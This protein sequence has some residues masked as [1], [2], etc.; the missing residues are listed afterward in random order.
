MKLEEKITI[1]RKKQ[2]WSQEELAFRLDV[3]R[4]AVSKWE[5][6]ASIPDLDKIIKMSEIFGV[7][8][9]YL[10]KDDATNEHSTTGNKIM[11]IPPKMTKAPRHV[12][13]EE[14][15]TYIETIK[16][17][18]REIAIG[19]ALCIL[20]PICLLLLNGLAAVDKLSNGLATG[21]GVTTL[22]IICAIAIKAFISGGMPLAKYAFL[23]EEVIEISEQ[24]Q[25]Q[26]KDKQDKENKIFQTAIAVGVAL[27]VL[28]AVPIIL[29]TALG[30]EEVGE[31]CGI[32][33]LLAMVAIA[34]FLFVKFGMIH[35]S[36]SKL[37]QE[38]EYSV[39]SKIYQNDEDEKDD[40]DDDCQQECYTDK[41]ES[42]VTLK[43][44]REKSLLSSVCGCL[45]LVIYLGVSFLTDRWDITWIMW[46]LY[47][48]ISTVLNF[49]LKKRNKSIAQIKS[50]KD[51]KKVLN[52]YSDVYWPIIT[53]IYLLVSFITGSWGITWIIWIIAVA[54]DGLLEAIIEKI[55]VKKQENE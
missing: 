17:S 2:G 36:Y 39:E 20:S 42:K 43:I 11:E 18:G 32:A 38:G 51:V 25:K 13:D 37:L 14:G 55:I 10:L 23:E 6:G 40:E 31:M 5:I 45:M 7:T 34:V 8:T 41:E 33:I 30:A 3:S 35:S 50:K 27:C 15:N 46:L 48:P 21:I 1:L 19:V 24:F 53:A 29:F 9:D 49:V 12:R 54:L 22:L 26:L 47:V 52:V 44:K 4:Q 28:A 16:R